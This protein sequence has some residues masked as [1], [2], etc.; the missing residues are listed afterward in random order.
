MSDMQ[1]CPGCIWKEH[2]HLEGCYHAPSQILLRA[3]DAEIA[4]L[5]VR[6]RAL[7][8][9]VTLAYEELD[10]RYDGADDSRTEWL[11]PILQDMQLT[12]AADDL[13]AEEGSKPKEEAK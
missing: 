1:T 10:N 13:A 4:W 7:R 6:A 5:R 2:T 3:K 8:S 12:L 9:A 11:G